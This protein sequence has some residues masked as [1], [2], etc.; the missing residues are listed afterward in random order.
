MLRDGTL[1]GFVGGQCARESV[2]VAA[3]DV[4]RD[5]KSLLLRVLPDDGVTFPQTPGARQTVNPCLS[6]G[7]LEI[8]LEPQLPAAVLQVTGDTPVA[9]A[10]ATLGAAL[11]YEVRDGLQDGPVAVVVA[12]HGHDEPETIRAALDAGVGFVGLVASSTRGAAVLDAM[13]LTADERAR[14]RTPVG[15]E[16]GAQTAEEIALSI[17]AAVV[18]AVRVDGL[19]ALVAPAL[20]VTAVDPVCGMTVV[21]GPD[22]PQADG[23]W[24]CCTGCR[25]SYQSAS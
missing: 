17:L 21:V 11:G 3:L 14:V 2:R 8:F 24:F 10:V 1:E 25:D 4:L 18:R 13:D 22:T 19:A 5:G 6:G 12:S 15:L 9:R 20:P 16:I 7:A 23:Q